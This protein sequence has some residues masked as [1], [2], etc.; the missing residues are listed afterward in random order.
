MSMLKPIL[1]FGALLAWLPAAA[2]TQC[3]AASG[4]YRVPLLE[5]YT[6]EGCDSC[7]PADRWL[8]GLPAKGY[9]PDRVVALA[10]HVDYWNYLG[11]VDRF[12]QQRFSERQRQIAARNQSRVVYTPQFTLN[13]K[14]YRRSPF[15]DDFGEKI[16]ALGQ[17]KPQARLH[18]E[19]DLSPGAVM[20]S[21]QA[22][23]P[24]AGERPLAQTWLALYENQLASE[25]GAGEN[26][27]KRLL[28][29]YVVRDLTG[30]FAPDAQ[31]RVLLK[32]RFAVDTLW[33]LQNLSVAA[34][35]QNARTG[36]VLQALATHCTSATRPAAASR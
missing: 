3:T 27:G 15:R 14:D 24:D 30:P 7:P 6:S 25:I 10:F 13:G 31:G 36:D 2:S 21:A 22:N 28:H 18:L 16:A 17:R 12:A 20:V 34:F 19:V 4:E 35:V 29:D 9:L 23:I 11:W 32:H 8:S 26:R 1:L 5:L 33:K